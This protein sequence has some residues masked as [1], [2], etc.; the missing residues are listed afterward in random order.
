M[1]YINLE[2]MKCSIQVPF[3]SIEGFAI[4]IMACIIA[5]TYVIVVCFLLNLTARFIGVQYHADINLFLYEK[6][7]KQDLRNFK[8]S[9]KI[10]ARNSAK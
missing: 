6:S 4:L 3:C 10:L 5:L 8:Q 7:T 2:E 9:S 1:K